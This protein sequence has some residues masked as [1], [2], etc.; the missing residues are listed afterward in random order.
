MKKQQQ[1]SSENSR[2][3]S[4]K[5]KYSRKKNTSKKLKSRHRYSRKK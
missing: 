5:N 2:G 4:I 3:G 1:P